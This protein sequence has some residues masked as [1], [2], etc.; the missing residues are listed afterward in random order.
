MTG[1]P[2][3][4]VFITD[5]NLLS[6]FLTKITKN[7]NNFLTKKYFNFCLFDTIVDAREMMTCVSCLIV[8]YPMAVT[9]KRTTNLSGV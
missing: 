9:P 1:V 6:D 2:T 3:F 7:K 8:K 4:L 5:G